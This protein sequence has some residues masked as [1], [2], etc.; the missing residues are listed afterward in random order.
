MELSQDDLSDGPRISEESDAE[1]ELDIDGVTDEHVES[2]R[3]ALASSLDSM[4]LDSLSLAPGAP[5]CERLT[6][7][8]GS[9]WQHEVG[10][11]LDWE[12]REPPEEESPE[13]CEMSLLD[14]AEALALQVRAEL[15]AADGG[16]PF[17]AGSGEAEEG[18]D[19]LFELLSGLDAKGLV[20]KLVAK[21]R[22]QQLSKARESDAIVE[23]R[24]A[25]AGERG[26]CA[27]RLTASPPHPNCRV[28][29]PPSILNLEMAGRLALTRC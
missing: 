18:D 14:E 3:S 15:R 16:D 13:L 28:A 17:G 10:A 22:R 8:L 2:L 5:D 1:I 11:S 7:T 9:D 27:H 4:P 23:A 19:E 29:P 12:T 26:R 21:R 6:S 24:R 20:T 25:L